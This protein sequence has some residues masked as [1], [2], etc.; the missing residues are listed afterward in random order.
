MMCVG[1][2]PQVPDT[3]LAQEWFDWSQR[4]GPW[5]DKGMVTLWLLSAQSSGRD[6]KRRQ[7]TKEA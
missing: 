6:G 3:G 7:A 2:D 4:S 5:S 1:R